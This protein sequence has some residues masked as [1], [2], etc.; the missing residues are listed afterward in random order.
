MGQP[1]NMIM[2]SGIWPVCRLHIDGLPDPVPCGWQSNHRYI[3]GMA[4]ACN[5]CPLCRTWWLHSS[6]PHAAM[7]PPCLG[8]ASSLAM[9]GLAHLAQACFRLQMHAMVSRL[10]ELLL[11]QH[12]QAHTMQS[13]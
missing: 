12:V 11:W 13:S 3:V 5:V 7:Q 9:H 6:S 1:L 10:S 4:T 2:D 8:S